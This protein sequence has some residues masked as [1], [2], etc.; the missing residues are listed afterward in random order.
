MEDASGF[1]IEN[2]FSKTQN[3]RVTC[4][5]FKLQL[6]GSTHSRFLRIPFREG[7]GNRPVTQHWIQAI[8]VGFSKPLGAKPHLMVRE[9]V[10]VLRF[11]GV[12]KNVLRDMVG[13]SARLSFEA[14]RLGA[15]Y[16]FLQGSF[17]LSYQPKRVPQQCPKRPTPFPG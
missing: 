2:T 15:G 13:K 14:S 3:A 16:T 6:P 4:S 10:P 12:A 11:V 17:F 8:L 5:Y 1:D 9:P 7:S